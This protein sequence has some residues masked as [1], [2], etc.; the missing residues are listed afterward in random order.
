MCPPYARQSIDKV[1]ED[2]SRQ[3]EVVGESNCQDFEVPI[4]LGWL[5]C[6]GRGLHGDLQQW[7]RLKAH[8]GL[9]C[10]HGTGRSHVPRVDYDVI[11]LGNFGSF[12][13]V[14]ILSWMEVINMSSWPVLPLINPLNYFF[15]STS[16]LESKTDIVRLTSFLREFLTHLTMIKNHAG[17]MF[18]TLFSLSI[19][20]L[21][22]Y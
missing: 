2:Y 15:W 6:G 7:R 18:Y 3:Y 13:H 4:P 14:A 21:P 17:S 8:R 12:L 22:L 1:S 9:Y 20:V 10:D 16:L 19:R 11:T 5:G